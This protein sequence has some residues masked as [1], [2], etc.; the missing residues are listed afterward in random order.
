MQQRVQ[1]TSMKLLTLRFSNKVFNNLHKSIWALL[2]PQ[3]RILVA[4][5]LG[6]PNNASFTIG[7]AEAAT[8]LHNP[9][10]GLAAKHEWKHGSISLF[11]NIGLET[12]PGI[13]VLAAP[14]CCSSKLS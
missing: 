3:H 6:S 7:I 12:L 10:A 13:S 4:A 14:T 9:Y 2:L 8:P 11:S 1:P 5:M